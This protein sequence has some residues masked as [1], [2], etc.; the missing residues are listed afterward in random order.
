MSLVIIN[1]L[2][3]R[4]RTLRAAAAR[5]SIDRTF[6]I[7]LISRDRLGRGV[8]DGPPCSQTNLAATGGQLPNLNVGKTPVANL[9]RPLR[10][11]FRLIVSP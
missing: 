1:T 5:G 4:V 7:S 6:A 9:F 8:L 2:P 10:D 3:V 11:L